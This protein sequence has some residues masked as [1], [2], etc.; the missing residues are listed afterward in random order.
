MQSRE[1]DGKQ[2]HENDPTAVSFSCKKNKLDKQMLEYGV[3]MFCE[4]W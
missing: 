3:C 4:V 2:F 1:L